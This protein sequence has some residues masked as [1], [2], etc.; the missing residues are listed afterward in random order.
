MAFISQLCI[1]ISVFSEQLKPKE[2][3]F[4]ESQTAQCFCACAIHICRPTCIN[5]P[6]PTLTTETSVL[7]TYL[8]YHCNRALEF[9]VNDVAT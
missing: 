6:E 3:S 9:Q 8:S 2:L 7:D 1:S 5:G 4:F